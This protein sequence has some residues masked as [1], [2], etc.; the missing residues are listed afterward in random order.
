MFLLCY[1]DLYIQVV[2]QHIFLQLQAL[3]PPHL[4]GLKHLLH[5]H[6]LLLFYVDVFS[7]KLSAP[8]GRRRFINLIYQVSIYLCFFIDLLYLLRRLWFFY[9]RLALYFNN[10][11]Y[12]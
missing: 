6:T 4:R 1:E 11:L 9:H 2:T 12:F 5:S 10:F 8:L 3:Q 7:W